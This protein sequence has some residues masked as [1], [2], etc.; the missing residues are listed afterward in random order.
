VKRQHSQL[1]CP[2]SGN[3]KVIVT[4]FRTGISLPF[5]TRKLRYLAKL[6]GIPFWTQKPVVRTNLVAKERNHIAMKK[7]KKMV[8]LPD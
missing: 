1:A 8:L 6:Y 2:A 5:R 4:L 7:K 3:K